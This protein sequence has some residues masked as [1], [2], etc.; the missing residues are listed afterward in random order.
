M[1]GLKRR[2][3]GVWA[4]GDFERRLGVFCAAGKDFFLAGAAAAFLGVALDLAATGLGGGGGRTIDEVCVKN[5]ED[6]EL[7]ESDDESCCR[8]VDGFGDLG[9][10]LAAG[11]LAV[12][13]FLLLG[14]VFPFS[15]CL[16]FEVGVLPGVVFR[17]LLVRAI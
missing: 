16:P 12:C 1:P 15:I 8:E 13:L 4:F 3:L 17:S 10:R 14:I 11:D 5:P 7:S 6:S 9:A 2:F